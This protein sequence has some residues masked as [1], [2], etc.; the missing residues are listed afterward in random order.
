MK[1]K[2]LMK[3]LVYTLLLFLPVMAN[4]QNMYNVTSLLSS[5]PAGTARFVGMGG[6]MGALGGD[7]SVMGVNPAGTAIYRSGDV[8]VTA[9]MD[10][11]NNKSVYGTDLLSKEY[12]SF[13]I[14]DFGFVIAC[15][16]ENS[17]FKFVNF[18]MNYRRNVNAGRNF[19]MNGNPGIFSQQNVI[20]G[21]YR[22]DPFDI[23][24]ISSEM[25]KGFEYNW[26]TLLAADGGLTDADGY[27]LTDKN[28]QL[29][30]IPNRFG[31]YSEERGGVRSLDLNLSANMDDR[32]YLGATLGVYIA[33]YSR[34]SYYYED[35]VDGEIYSLVNNYMVE[36]TG[37]DLKLGAI[38]RPF[39]YSPFKIGVS[40][41]TP[42][43]YQ[44]MDV[45]SA[46]IQGPYGDL[47]DTR[48]T[49][50]YGDDL[51]VEYSL[52][53][54][55]RF[56]TSMSYTFG[57]SVALNA[58]YEYAN[59]ASTRFSNKTGIG[60]AQNEEI[61]CNLKSQHT[62]RLG[63]EFYIK[64]CALRAGYNYISSPFLNRAYKNLGNATVT[65][66]ST[67]YMN[68]FGKHVGTLGLG[69]AGKRFYVDIA[70]MLQSQKS[71]FYAYSDNYQGNLNPATKVDCLS[72]S[73]VAGVGVR[74]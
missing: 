7:V 48:D 13:S 70:Y 25:Y 28:D 20:D 51:R 43:F 35:D 34:Y 31:Y 53:T 30:F 21:L 15:E 14:S 12:T 11:V 68:N 55:W 26:L 8:N 38:F 49:E 2:I 46:S 1:N 67:E 39:Q 64:K 58:E 62:V 41:H 40:V 72:H 50:C 3:R 37:F 24:D 27:L 56:N 9:V 18:G 63:A 74:F 29:I 66:T 65:D 59:A 42:V 69:Y 5:N 52:Q 57:Q 23:T 54:P 47:Y 33:D 6:S 60:R 10:I 36:G 17:P 32:V 44:L 61:V 22:D 45:S 4:A 73:V 71:D 16:N 19:E